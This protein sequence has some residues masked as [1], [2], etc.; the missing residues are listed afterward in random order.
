MKRILGVLAMLVAVQANAGEVTVSGAWSRATV[1]GQDAGMVQLVITSKQAA[2]LVGVTSKDAGKA[3]LHSMVHENG[4]MKMRQ[5]AAID[6][7]A[8]KAVDL[9]EEG[10]HVMLM[11]LKQPLK[12]GEKTEI[13]L[14]VRFASGKE[15]Q[16]KVN[17]DIKPQSEPAQQM[18]MNMK[19]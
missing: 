8:G 13:T 19:M 18:K 11:G 2:K 16:V 14:T 5:V 17:A 12:A 6:L 1:P 3:E 7:A 9:G 15:E 10:Y 4:V